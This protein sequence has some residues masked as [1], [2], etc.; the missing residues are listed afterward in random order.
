VSARTT[1]SLM[2]ALGVLAMAA[3]GMR[4]YATDTTHDFE[5][6]KI[7]LDREPFGPMNGAAVET[8]AP[9]FATHYTFVGTAQVAD[10]QPLLAII[11]DKEGNR[12]YFKGEGDSLGAASVVKIERPEKGPAKLVLKQ[13][14]ETATLVLEPKAGAVPAAGASVPA[15]QPVQP[16]QPGVPPTIQPGARRIPFHRG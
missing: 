7:I 2:T 9:G 10:D 14:L 8:A 1:T 11:V 6:Y 13:G 16:G 12:V 3:G 15:G 4:A 5:R